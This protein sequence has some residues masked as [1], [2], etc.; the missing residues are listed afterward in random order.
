MESRSSH[1]NIECRVLTH[2]DSFKS[3]QHAGVCNATLIKDMGVKHR[4]LAGCKE[5]RDWVQQQEAQ[6]LTAASSTAK[7]GGQV[8]AAAATLAAM[9]AHSTIASA[10]GCAGAVA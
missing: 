10:P 3:L 5:V 7:A 6:E 2:R 1:T 9:H 4:L 8:G